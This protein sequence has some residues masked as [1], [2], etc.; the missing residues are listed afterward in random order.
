MNLLE[1]IRIIIVLNYDNLTQ[2]YTAKKFLTK[3]YQK[4]H[5]SKIADRFI[6]F[7]ESREILWALNL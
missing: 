3:K 5:L 6:D 7:K 2:L 4:I 1:V